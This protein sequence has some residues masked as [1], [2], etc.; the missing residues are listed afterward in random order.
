MKKAIPVIAAACVS[1]VG[2]FEAGAAITG[3]SGAATKISAPSSVRFGALT[4]DT[5]MFVFDE[6]QNVTLAAGITVDITQP[7]VYTA[8]AQ[9]TPGTI[10][11]GTVVS[12]HFIHC[13][14]TDDS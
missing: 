8:S 6:R 4:S 14:A 5:T 11:A 12:S 7:G 13:D 9:L 3:T 2:A 10:T 1:L